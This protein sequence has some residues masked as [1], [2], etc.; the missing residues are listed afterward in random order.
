[1]YSVHNAADPLPEPTLDFICTDDDPYSTDFYKK[2]LRS[3]SQANWCGLPPLLNPRKMVNLGFK[4]IET[5]KVQCIEPDCGQTAFVSQDVC[6]EQF[7]STKTKGGPIAE[8][9]LTRLSEQTHDFNCK[10]N[11]PAFKLQKVFKMQPELDLTVPLEIES[12]V[13]KS[14]KI[15]FLR[16]QEIVQ[17]LYRSYPEEF[18]GLDVAQASGEIVISE[19]G[20]AE[21]LLK[22][23]T[24][25]KEAEKE[26]SDLK[27]VLSLNGWRWITDRGHSLQCICC[28]QKYSQSVFASQEFDPIKLHQSFCIFS[29]PRGFK[30]LK[31]YAS[32]LTAQEQRP[33]ASNKLGELMST[34]RS[35]QR[36]IQNQLIEKLK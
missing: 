32:F 13:V 35:Y 34:F 21:N 20:G 7:D 12:L 18:V 2:Y 3:F 15:L 23:K 26:V 8:R 24:L 11:N 19:I 27:L 36:V 25:V 6:F 22:V 33:L 29:E 31:L 1:M 10:W 30:A 17:L 14:K 16:W 9:Q 28:L 4:C 5:R